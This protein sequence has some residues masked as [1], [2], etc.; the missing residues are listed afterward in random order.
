MSTNIILK[1]DPSKKLI[2]YYY[3]SMKKLILLNYQIIIIRFYANC[4]LFATLRFQS[5]LVLALKKGGMN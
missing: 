3:L 1:V 4:V 2:Y 5:C